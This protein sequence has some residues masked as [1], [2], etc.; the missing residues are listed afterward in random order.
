METASKLK[1]NFTT[2]AD[3]KTLKISNLKKIIKFNVI[4]AKKSQNFETKKITL[5]SFSIRIVSNF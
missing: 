4:F 2:M 5:D 1:A 3:Q